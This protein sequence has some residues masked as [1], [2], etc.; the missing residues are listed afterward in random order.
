[1]FES[2]QPIK[3]KS[4]DIL[5]RV[6]FAKYFGNSILS[7]ESEETLI[8]GLFG[9][10]G[11]GKSSIVNLTIENI[12]SK[13]F[14]D[15]KYQPVI[16]NFNP[17][18]FSDQNNLVQQFF[19]SISLNLK[20]K[21]NGKLLNKVG[22]LTEDY[23][24]VL[25]P[26]LISST[27]IPGL[28]KIL[29][30]LGKGIKEYGNK[31]MQD[32]ET[33]KDSISKKLK[34]SEKKI[35][36]VIDDIDRLN[37]LEIKQIFQLVKSL[38]DF[39]NIIYIL[40]FDRNIVTKILDEEQSGNG[41]EYLEKI[42]QIPI[43]IP[44]VSREYLYPIL[45]KGI[46]ELLLPIEIDEFDK[47]YW[48]NIF[49]YG[50]SDYFTNLRKIKRYLNILK[51][52]Y[53]LVNEDVNPVD[54]LILTSFQVFLPELY[55]E[56]KGNK[57]LFTSESKSFLD[58]SL[59]KELS[60]E[61]MEYE[62]I[63][64]QN[65]NVISEENL[66]NILSRMFPKLELLK[67]EQKFYYSDEVMNV[68]NT[69][70]RIC[71][72][73]FFSFYFKLTVDNEFLSTNELNSILNKLDNYEE[74]LRICTELI[75][76][77]KISLFLTSVYA[78]LAILNPE[79][80]KII[81][82]LLL[83]TGDLYFNDEQQ[84]TILIIKI[85]RN[86]LSETEK[87]KEIEN[88]IISSKN[89]LY[90]CSKLVDFLDQEHLQDSTIPDKNR[91]LLKENIEKL[92]KVISEQIKGASGNSLLNHSKLPYLLYKWKFW[93]DIRDFE[94]FLNECI[95]N[96]NSLIKFITG[97]SHTVTSL[98]SG[99]II[100][101]VHYDLYYN[102]LKKILDA[103]MENVYEKVKVIID[104]R[105]QLKMDDREAKSLKLFLDNYEN[106]IRRR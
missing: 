81:L 36:I 85:L 42:I 66:H 17:W 96:N 93:G 39:P 5:N 29:K 52:G 103:K 19:K 49:N 84:T 7:H 77:N 54:F 102:D 97:F 13:F 98:D 3:S 58:F 80:K 56:I 4:E 86:M 38:A 82:K 78:R 43:E 72:P 26:I 74:I 95:E 24:A 23:S 83:D 32:L 94:N 9:E 89:G 11:S 30:N 59:S 46:D 47:Y 37:N 28:S 15:N 27:G 60:E 70:K 33:V 40:S 55:N 92:K 88:D 25:E 106:K 101:K 69:K 61:K 34:N 76:S 63:L 75:E 22:E 2:D 105:M 73:D 21:E 91:I 14:D 31:K 12:K 57:N 18:N 1:M 104:N 35:I 41:K 50:I 100:G 10:W 68:W 65:A 16:I 67:K 6:T 99:D 44:Q 8:I 53:K 45:F 48:S 79:N 90:T 87:L 64:K 71:H 51:F 62:R 20:R